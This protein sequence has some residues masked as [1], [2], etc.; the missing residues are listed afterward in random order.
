MTALSSSHGRA[1]THR[2][3]ARLRGDP[4]AAVLSV[5]PSDPRHVTADGL[6]ALVRAA[7][8]GAEPG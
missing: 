1:P 7:W 5:V 6:T 4:G 8:E 2:P 3:G